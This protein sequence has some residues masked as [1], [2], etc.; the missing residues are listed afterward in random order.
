LRVTAPDGVVAHALYRKLGFEE[1][2]ERLMERW[3]R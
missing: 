2:D 3:V 1:P